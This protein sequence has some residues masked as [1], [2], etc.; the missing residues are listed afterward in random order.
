MEEKDESK[1]AMIYQTNATERVK[2][3][4]FGCFYGKGELYSR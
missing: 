1:M 4:C 2:D 3:V